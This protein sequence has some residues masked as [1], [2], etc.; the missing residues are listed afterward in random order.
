MVAPAARARPRI[1]ASGRCA[2][3]HGYAVRAPMS[4]LAMPA[5]SPPRQRRAFALVLLLLGS[6]GVAAAWTLW[7]LSVERQSA[8]IA[9]LAAADAALLLRLAKVPPGWARALLAVAGTV[10]AVLLANWWI[11]GGEM[12]RQLGMQPWNSIPRLGLHHFLALAELA[13][14]G[15]EYAW[16]AAAAVLAAVAGR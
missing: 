10:L 2:S 7:A 15:T 9:L 13:N 4:A 5:A 1:L 8:W 11:A 16:Y 14:R 12:G 6:A 3:P